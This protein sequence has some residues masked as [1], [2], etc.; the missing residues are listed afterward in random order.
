MQPYSPVANVV[1]LTDDTDDQVQLL[2]IFLCVPSFLKLMWGLHA[3]CITLLAMHASDIW[4][5]YMQ[6]QQAIAASL[7]DICHADQDIQMRPELQAQQ[8]QQF[9]YYHKKHLRSWQAPDSSLPSAPKDEQ[10]IH[11][12]LGINSQECIGPGIAKK[13]QQLDAT[14]TPSE[15]EEGSQAS[16]TS[17]EPSLSAQEPSGTS[18][19]LCVACSQSLYIAVSLIAICSALSQIIS[20]LSPMSVWCWCRSH[21]R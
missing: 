6:L 21:S 19:S 12:Q 2:L 9:E 8:L 15:K 13:L 4:C 3:C 10:H 1:D 11:S 18:F 17:A 7:L 16:T 20:G 5:L 14:A